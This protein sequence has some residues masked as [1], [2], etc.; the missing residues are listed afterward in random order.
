MCELVQ[1]CDKVKWSSRQLFDEVTR[2]EDL[3]QCLNAFVLSAWRGGKKDYLWQRTRYVVPVCLQEGHEKEVSISGEGSAM[4]LRS[5]VV[6]INAM[7]ARLMAQKSLAIWWEGDSA[8]AKQK[9]IRNSAAYRWTTRWNAT[10]ALLGWEMPVPGAD[11]LRSVKKLVWPHRACKKGA[12]DGWVYA[13]DAN[14]WKG[15]DPKSSSGFL[16]GE[17]IG[18]TAKMMKTGLRRGR[19]CS[20]CED[21]PSKKVTRERALCLLQASVQ[22]PASDSIPDARG[23]DR[24]DAGP[25]T[26]ARGKCQACGSIDITT[27]FPS[28]ICRFLEHLSGGWHV[29]AGILG[30]GSRPSGTIPFYTLA[31]KKTGHDLS[32]FVFSTVMGVGRSPLKTKEKG[33]AGHPCVPTRRQLY[34][35]EACC[36]F[37]LSPNLVSP[38]CW[39]HHFGRGGNRQLSH[40]LVRRKPKPV[41]AANEHCIED[42]K[43][44]STKED[45]VAV[46]GHNP[47]EAAFTPVHLVRRQE[48]DEGGVSGPET[49]TN[50]PMVR[51]LNIGDR[52]MTKWEALD[53][54]A[55]MEKRNSAEAKYGI[56]RR[57]NRDQLQHLTFL[58]FEF[59]TPKQRRRFLLHVKAARGHRARE[60]TSGPPLVCNLEVAGPKAGLL[61]QMIAG[62]VWPLIGMVG[63]S[64]SRKPEQ[65]IL[66]LVGSEHRFQNCFEMQEFQCK[67]EELWQ[68]ANRMGV[69]ENLRTLPVQCESGNEYH[70][71]PLLEDLL[72]QGVDARTPVKASLDTSLKILRKSLEAKLPKV[73]RQVVPK[74]RQ[75]QVTMDLVD[76]FSESLKIMTSKE[77]G[78]DPAEQCV[79]DEEYLRR[80]LRVK[81]FCTTVVDK[82]PWRAQVSCPA[83]QYEATCFALQEHHT[84]IGEWSEC[85]WSGWLQD[86]EVFFESLGPCGFRWNKRC[87]E[88]MA[89]TVCRVL[90]KGKKLHLIDTMKKRDRLVVSYASH[91]L[92]DVFSGLSRC[93]DALLV[94]VAAE[95]RFECMQGGSASLFQKD[96]V[97][98]YCTRGS[99]RLYKQEKKMVGCGHFLGY[100]RG[101]C[102]LASTLRRLDEIRRQLAV[103][104]KAAIAMTGDG[105]PHT[106]W[107]MTSTIWIKKYDFEAFFLKAPRQQVLSAVQLIVDTVDRLFPR[108]SFVSVKL[109][110]LIQMEKAV[111]NPELLPDGG[112]TPGVQTMGMVAEV[113]YVAARHR[114]RVRL[115]VARHDQWGWACFP[116]QKIVEALEE[117]WKT[118]TRFGPHLYQQVTGLTIGSHWGASGCATWATVKEAQR[119]VFE[120]WIW[121][122]CDEVQSRVVQDD[123]VPEWVACCSLTQK[124]ACDRDPRDGAASA[125]RWVDD[126][127]E[128]TSGPVLRAF[129][130]HHL[131]WMVYTLATTLLQVAI[132][133]VYRH[134]RRSTMGSPSGEIEN[135]CFGTQPFETW[136]QVWTRITLFLQDTV[137][138][139]VEAPES[140]VGIELSWLMLKHR[141]RP[142]MDA[143]Q[144][145]DLPGVTPQAQTYDKLFVQPISSA[146]V[147]AIQTCALLARVQHKDMRLLEWVERHSDLWADDVVR[148]ECNLHMAKAGR[149]KSRACCEQMAKKSVPVM[150]MVSNFVR[151][152]LDCRRKSARQ[153]PMLT[154]LYR[155]M[156]ILHWAIQH[157]E[158]LRGCGLWECGVQSDAFVWLLAPF[159]VWCLQVA[160]SGNGFRQS[161]ALVSRAAL[162]FD[163]FPEGARMLKWLC[164]VA[165][166]IK[167]LGWWTISRDDI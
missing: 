4:Y 47:G 55:K 70:H 2:L 134:A 20:Q 122:R 166:R 167:E 77:R 103:Q 125:V 78:F 19:T 65:N 64:V 21:Q 110:E 10:L 72:P 101:V 114:D 26:T 68:L 60:F 40:V 143:A 41:P 156:E 104:H 51:R 15:V 44:V 56:L 150:S 105:V 112:V 129:L 92:R 107:S 45:A 113:D 165:Y 87:E 140:F 98:R 142:A 24:A 12:I 163:R 33:S 149:F 148:C 49:A 38:W 25:C 31:K 30:R 22:K 164:A 93:L 66:R 90:P 50:F 152:D 67:C 63:L 138:Q 16:R 157:Q 52:R 9:T 94:L 145:T 151:A 80:R 128:W 132:Q 82:Q 120:R 61:S 117:D 162:K 48:Q 76:L 27:E 69:G 43:K 14:P 5:V 34:S 59:L 161:L 1:L 108:S 106:G 36:H 95:P 123:P 57:L 126:R 154:H 17:Y 115:H 118:V 58:S 144:S 23:K 135:G 109:P 18:S 32:A 100:R 141:A 29:S 155:N 124:S 147:M 97:G 28:P 153:A 7:R 130:L 73:L 46:Q 111:D 85:W 6:L 89:P 136:V 131:G 119:V 91:P 159:V 62:A 79:T 8:W 39:P 99:K 146:P 42:P 83:L 35:M 11:N 75:D 88:T 54:W 84:I 81:G 96:P 37:A 86:C 13:M 3:L 121:R 127:I 116:P 102:S 160:E 158:G 53:L 71:W 137:V 74:K 139:T 133:L